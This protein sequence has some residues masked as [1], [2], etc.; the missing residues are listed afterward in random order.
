MASITLS[1]SSASGWTNSS[2]VTAS[3]NSYATS[4]VE[5]GEDFGGSGMSVLLTVSFP[6]AGLAADDVIDGVEVRIERKLSSSTGG[7]K[8][9]QLEVAGSG[10]ANGPST[11]T[12]SDV[13]ETNG[14]PSDL[15]GMSWTAASFNSGFDVAFRA[16]FN[17]GSSTKTASVDYV[18]VTIYYH[19][20]LVEKSVADSGTVTPGDAAAVAA[21]LSA[22]DA[23]TVTV[24]ETAH[25]EVVV[26]VSASDA[27]TVSGAE[28]VVGI[29]VATGD[30]DVA[31][32]SE[33][34]SIS[35]GVAGGDTDTATGSD[36]SSGTVVVTATDS[37]TATVSG[38]TIRIALSAADSD[39]VTLAEAEA[40]RRII[41]ITYDPRLA[42]DVYDAAGNRVGSGPIVGILSADYS[43]RLDEIGAWSVSVDATEP[44]AAELT[45]GRE[46]WIRRE[47]EGLLLRGTIETPDLT[48]G[49]VDDRILTISGRSVAEQLVRKNTLLGRTFSGVSVAA[50][51]ADLLTGTGWTAGTVDAGTLLSARFDG[52][53]IWA[54]L[55]QVAK[56]QGWHLREDN[57]NRRVSLTSA[58]TSSGLVIRNVERAD[59]DLAVIPLARLRIT[60][61]EPELW[62]T[63]IPLGAGQ[64]VN[65]LTLEHAAGGGAYTVQTATGPDGEPYWYLQ[66][67]ASVA[68]YGERTKVMTIDQVAPLS[69]SAA[70]I[71]AAAGT[72]Y[73]IASAWLSYY[74][75]PIDHY[76]ADV[77]LL[78]HIVAGTPSFLLGQTVRLQ[79]TGIVEDDAGRRRWRHV[80]DD[81]YIMG[82]RRTFQ[83]DGS[84]R[85]TL[86][87]A[88]AAQHA[89]G[90]ADVIT[91][92]IEDLWALKVAMRPYTYREI[93]GP[94][95][96]S[97]DSTHNATV[98]I[99]YDDSVTYLHRAE[100]RLVKRRVRSNVATAAAGGSPTSNT[101]TTAANA[102]GGV[103]SAGGTSHTHS[104]SAAVT[105]DDIGEHYH[106]IGQA[107][108]TSSWTDPGYL[109]QMVFASTPGGALNY[110]IYG[111][112]NGTEGSAQGLWTSGFT[113]HKHNITAS[114]TNSES[115]HTH[116]LPTHT[117][118][119]NDHSHTMPTHTHSLNYGIYDGPA[120]A[121]PAFGI[122]VNAV[123]ITSALGGP[124]NGDVVLDIT[125]WL[126][127]ANGHILRQGN[128]LVVS[129][130]QLCDVELTVKS[131]VSALSV[132]PV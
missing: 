3:D 116:T 132:V 123:D 45:R 53:S 10:T 58:G 99:D 83:P 37:D 106:Q 110:G 95:R 34:A 41:P 109:Q 68:D 2:N 75:H 127:D 78:R 14:T 86:E 66:D 11:W 72:L 93:H 44:N 30:S 43:G 46:V 42:L 125:P 1:P 71:E 59:T 15:W 126:V 112:R 56:I 36:A 89:G 100:L 35:A 61:D 50:A 79:Y 63:L 118:T 60:G 96:E 128:S 121:T 22:G 12:T 124:W 73:A 90:A 6:A 39:T 40:E 69:N 113:F 19:P 9:I 130:S 104:I 5:K 21:T 92:A 70:E 108:P 26:T 4:T 32:V 82:Y 52:V 17:N 16:G 115:S 48:V 101:T 24:T 38:E 80:D 74:A 85:W 84:D 97:V 51:V 54:A 114:A 81:V 88:T 120:A 87:L 57:L 98:T 31:T 107:Q 29:T 129:S 20:G 55:R 77:A 111:G 117:H 13:T 94:Y 103:T 65:V 102:G 105:S 64:G 67:A 62:N 49:D 119:I 27:G 122:K 28:S 7:T 47:G 8:T 131:F 18:S 33:T 91:T 23:D 25:V 76:E